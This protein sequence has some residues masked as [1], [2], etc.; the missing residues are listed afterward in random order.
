[1]L[2][3]DKTVIK[4]EL[5]VP[6]VNLT[7]TLQIYKVYRELMSNVDTS[8]MGEMLAHLGERRKGLGEGVRRRRTTET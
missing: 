7:L 2:Q 8:N 4:E 5:S 6:T 3:C 1:M